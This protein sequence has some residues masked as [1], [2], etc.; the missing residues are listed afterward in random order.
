VSPPLR[1]HQDGRT[2]T[3]GREISP[4]ERVGPQVGAR[5]PASLPLPAIR[6]A[7][8]TEAAQS[9][10]ATIAAISGPQPTRASRA[11]RCSRSRWIRTNLRCFTLRVRTARTR[12]LRAVSHVGMGRVRQDRS[13]MIPFRLTIAVAFREMSGPAVDGS[14]CGTASPGFDKHLRGQNVEVSTTT[15]DFRKR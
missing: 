8:F 7:K 5:D 10:R 2:R 15:I 9:T 4:I 12:R 14:A 1:R 13:V 3:T 6:G 11:S